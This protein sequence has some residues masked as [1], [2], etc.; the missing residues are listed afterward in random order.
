MKNLKTIY[1]EVKNKKPELFSKPEHEHLKNL[2][3]NYLFLHLFSNISYQIIRN[4]RFML[5]LLNAN[6]LSVAEEAELFTLATLKGVYNDFIQYN[7]SDLLGD[8]TKNLIVYLHSIY[9]NAT[10][11]Q[12]EMNLRIHDPFLQ[13]LIGEVM[14]FSKRDSIRMHKLKHI[15][16][17]LPTASLEDIKHN[18]NYMKPFLKHGNPERFLIHSKI[19]AIIKMKVLEMDDVDKNLN[20][21][22]PESKN[23]LNLS[24]TDLDIRIYNFLETLED[25]VLE[26]ER[27]F[28]PKLSSTCVKL[29][30]KLKTMN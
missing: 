18:I 23:V 24:E 6:Q 4:T 30:N 20:A 27:A 19:K 1:Y 9:S 29:Y 16:K 25:V 15:E 13:E 2:N 21:I 10:V 28:N 26:I 5:E 3:S 8:P 12:V 11:L 17:S 7:P 14:V 22:P